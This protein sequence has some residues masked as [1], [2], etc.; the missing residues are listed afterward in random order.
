MHL[1]AIGL[2]ACL[3]FMTQGIATAQ[4]SAE[5]NI[6]GHWT[7]TAR[8][9]IDCTFAGTARFERQS[10][11]TYIGEL[12]ATQSCPDLEQDFIVRQD[13]Q[14]SQSGNQVSVRCQIT[15][16]INGFGSDYYYP[17]NFALTVASQDRMH[18]ALLSTGE[19]KPAEWVRAEGAI[20]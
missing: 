12:V 16:F 8:L 13:C 5:S 9:Q 14:V 1:S 6:A 7:F 18:G 15:E 3:T 11:R 20:S 10:S 4:D 19:A 2:A 17:D